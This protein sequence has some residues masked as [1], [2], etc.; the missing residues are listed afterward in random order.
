[1][2]QRGGPPRLGRHLFLEGCGRT[3]L[4]GG[5]PE[6]MYES[7]T[8]RLARFGDDTIL[9]PGHFYA[10]EPSATLG[11][12]RHHNYVFKPRTV[13]QWLTMFGS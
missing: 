4:P 13:E 11:E 1:V 5:D 8:T 6:E 12:T 10:A 2:L 9:Y 7:I 3:D